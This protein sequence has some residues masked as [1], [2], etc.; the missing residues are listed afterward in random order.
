MGSQSISHDKRLRI[1]VLIKRF[2]STGGAERYAL[3]VTRRLAL[4]HEVHVFAH[5]WSFQGKEAINFHKIPSW[6]TKPS[7]LNQLLFSSLTNRAVGNAF[8]IVHSHEKVAR[9]DVMTI[10]SPCF[11]SFITQEKSRWKRNLIWLSVGISPRQLAWLSIERKQFALHPERLFIAVSEA[12]KRDAQANYPLPNNSFHIAYPGVDAH[13]TKEL[14]ALEGRDKKRS[15]LG[16]AQDDF[17]ILFVGTEFK[18]K[19]LDALLRALSLIPDSRYRLVV[20]G[21][22]GGKMR[23]YKDLVNHLRLSERVLFLGL[24]ENVGELYA[25]ADAVILPTLSD[26]WGMAPMEAMLCGVPAA[27]SSTD[28]CGAAEYIKNNEALIIKDP[29]DPH[30]IADTMRQLMEPAVRAELERRGQA[31][32]AELTWERTTEATLSAYHEVLRR[33]DQG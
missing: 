22:G 23:K 12:V 29:T 31:L 24:V 17:L 1:A 6:V 25:L 8:D 28:Y 3:E 30:E 16:F 15:G 2:I 4:E 13:I 21:G 26:P 18:R 20:A 27:L 10:H 33:K 5:D 19:G 9:F 32:A 11:R 7:W 14:Q